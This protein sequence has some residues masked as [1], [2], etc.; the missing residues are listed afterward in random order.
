MNEMLDEKDFAIIDELKKN[1]KLSEQKIARKTGIPMT[2]VHN[3]IKKLRASDIIEAF[4]IRLNYKRMNL[5][6]V[7]YVLVKA[8]PGADQKVLLSKIAKLPN[9][10]QAAMITGEFDILFMARVGSMEELNSI[11][12]QKLRKMKF[13]GE[14]RTM[15]SYEIIEKI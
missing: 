11:V 9:V 8:L 3:R 12:V 5:P 2:T 7:A 10:Y 1:S 4:T 14:T 15:I 6:I 13:V